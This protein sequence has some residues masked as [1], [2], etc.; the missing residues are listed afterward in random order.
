MSRI[1]GVLEA[2]GY[3]TFLP[4]RDG[5]ERFVL[6]LSRLPGTDL[7]GIAAAGRTLERAIFALDLY[8]I[9]ER[10]DALVFNMNGRVPDEGGVAESALA[11]ASGKPVVIYKHDHRSLL[12]GRDNPLLIGLSGDFAAVGSLGALPERLETALAAAERDAASPYRG[13]AIPPRVRRSLRRGRRIWRLLE[14]VSAPGS[15]SE[16]AELCAEIAG[17]EAGDS[18]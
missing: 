17:L 12:G 14:R 18:D 15:A 16:V 13:E 1:A 9:V 11:F 10:C 3:Q 8:Q 4:H 6:P 2:A 5:L 7:P